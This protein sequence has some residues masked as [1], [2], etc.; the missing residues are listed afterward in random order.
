MTIGTESKAAIDT[1]MKFSRRKD[2]IIASPELPNTFFIPA[3]LVLDCARKSVRLNNPNAA[4]IRVRSANIET[5]VLRFFSE[6]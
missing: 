3:S 1:R 2:I 6:E 4:I 5:M